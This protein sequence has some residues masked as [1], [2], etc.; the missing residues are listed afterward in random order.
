MDA[1]ERRAGGLPLCDRKRL[2]PAGT[3]ARR[4]GR[5]PAVALEP[6]RRRPARRALDAR[7]RRHQASGDHPARRQAG[8]A[9]LRPVQRSAADQSP[10]ARSRR[11]VSC[12]SR[13]LRGQ[14]QHVRCRVQRGAAA[15][16][17]CR[18]GTPVQE[19]ARGGA[20]WQRHTAAGRRESGGHSQG[21]RRAAAALSPVAQ[22]RARPRHLPRLRSARAAHRLRSEVPSTPKSS[23]RLS[24]R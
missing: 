7:Q 24:N 9:D 16:L 14:W 21:R 20:S 11:R 15:R 22:A 19:H 10:S 18:T 17:V 2:S 4:K 3:R 12:L 13:D 23:T 8:D 5:A 1:G 6:P